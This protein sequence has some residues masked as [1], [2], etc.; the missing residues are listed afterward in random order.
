LPVVAPPA[1]PEH[2]PAEPLSA[3]P[4][5]A[6]GFHLFDQHYVLLGVGLA[7]PC[8]ASAVEIE[9]SVV[10]WIS[11]GL[12]WGGFYGSLGITSPRPAGH[13]PPSNTTR[14]FTEAEEGQP[15]G[16]S[17]RRSEPNEVSSDYLPHGHRLGLGFEGGWRFIAAD[18]GYLRNS[19]LVVDERLDGGSV[20]ESDATIHGFRLRIGVAVA[21]EIFTSSNSAYSYHCCT[22]SLGKDGKS[23]IACECERTAVGVS[24]FLYYGNELYYSSGQKLWDDGMLGLTLKIGVG[25]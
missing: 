23:A 1:E 19:A 9:S 15:S 2:P 10:P 22:N 21:H 8:Q 12:W 7:A 16:I 18:I 11:H 25:L 17:Y 5:L 6:T 3:S 13:P 4:S 20:Q 14:C 24:L